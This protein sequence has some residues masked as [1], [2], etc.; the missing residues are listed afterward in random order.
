MNKITNDAEE[1]KND[2]D[3]D[4]VSV[5]PGVPKVPNPNILNGTP[6]IGD[7]TPSIPDPDNLKRDNEPKNEWPD[8]SLKRDGDGLEE[9]DK[10]VIWRPVD[11]DETANLDI[12]NP[13]NDT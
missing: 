1:M 3:D 4:G 12:T 11:G 8:S 9:N 10:D 6:V 7:E 13:A 5:N 2:N